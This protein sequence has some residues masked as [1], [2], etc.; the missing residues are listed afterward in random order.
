MVVPGCFTRPTGDL[1][2]QP[3]SRNVHVEACR[4]RELCRTTRVAPRGPRGH[5][6]GLRRRRALGLACAR[7]VALLWLEELA[8]L[9]AHLLAVLV[10]VHRCRVLSGC[11]DDLLLLADDRQRAVRLARPAT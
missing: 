9:T 4:P 10:S 7:L 5:R 11:A 3:T 6:S 1:G 2:S 8:D